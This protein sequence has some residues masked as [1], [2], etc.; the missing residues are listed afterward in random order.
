MSRRSARLSRK[1]A[2]DMLISG[3]Y[4]ELRDAVEDEEGTEVVP[5][6]KRRK[7]NA[8]STTGIIKSSSFVA[9]EEFPSS[10]GDFPLDIVAEIFRVGRLSPMDLLNLARTSKG[11][12]GT[13]MSRSSAFM[14]KQSRSHIE[15]LPDLPRDLSEPQYANLCFST[16]CHEC[17][18][19]RVLT[20]IW[21]ARTRLCNK[22]GTHKWVASRTELESALLW[23]L[24]PTHREWDYRRELFS[25]DEARRLSEECVV[26]RED[27]ELQMS[28][29][30][31][32]VWFTQK[33]D[34]LEEINAHARLCAVWAANRTI[35]RK[36]QLYEARGLRYDAI[37]ERLT[38]LGWAEDMFH[39]PEFC[40]H[41]L[42]NQPKKLTD[43]I[44]KNI[45]GPLVELLAEL[46][47][48]RER[49]DAIKNRQ[50]LAARVYDQFREASPP[51]ML[52]PPRIDVL[53][54]EPFRVVIE[55]TLAEEVLTE[56]S[57]AAAISSVAEFSVGWRR[58]KEKEL[59]KIMRKNRPGAVQADLHLAT[60]FFTCSIYPAEPLRFPAILV[61][62]SATEFDEWGEVDS[63]EEDEDTRVDLQYTLQ[64]AAW[65]A[66]DCVQLQ[67][68]AQRSA[69]FI[70]RA[71]GL[72][73][74]VTTGAEMDEINPA[75][76][77]LNCSNKRD[78]HLVMRWTQATILQPNHVC[79]SPGIPS[80]RCLNPDEERLLENKELQLLGTCSPEQA[81]CCK[82][83][84][85][86]RRVPLST[87]KGHLL[88][89]HGI[90]DK[91]LE[92]I[93]YPLD[94]GPADQFPPP[95]RLK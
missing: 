51:G 88:A 13:L 83:C 38:A 1:V 10:F 4:N 26:F 67:E 30:D 75:L 35:E 43:R 44:W 36:D 68:R 16:H 70:V 18:A 3:G 74:D 32:Q 76:E 41:K 46:K 65:N 37:V 56:E 42:V 87:M 7:V 84:G 11:I 80:W 54:T 50:R 12:R 59:I 92:N 39:R 47:E 33:K 55:D 31:Y 72:D 89:E 20:I 24:I 29:P 79:D 45:Q 82:V 62:P 85:D 94:V 2:K 22:F 9:A 28:N 34:A 8:K 90:S 17:L 91:V 48:R 93:V 21:S 86:S 78:G 6:K 23:S 61:H 49:V 60:T 15:G 77:C 5:R 19:G 40:S 25:V 14:W 63:E 57:F 58:R 81:C 71:C 95:V 73:P 64:E 27:G 66:D 69:R 53:L 52:L